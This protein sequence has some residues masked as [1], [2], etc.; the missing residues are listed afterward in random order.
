M[1]GDGNE[2]A[3]KVGGPAELSIWV[4]LGPISLKNAIKLSILTGD[5][6]R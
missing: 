2:N 1:L 6:S 5:Y 3:K 4:V